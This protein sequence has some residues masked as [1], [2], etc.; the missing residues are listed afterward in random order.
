PEEI[1]R[2][3]RELRRIVRD[4]MRT[5]ILCDNA[6]QCERLDEL[7]ADGG[8]PSPAALTVG[9]L[10]GGFV[11][12]SPDGAGLR[13]LTDHEIFRRERRIRRARTYTS[14]ITGDTLS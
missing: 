8:V 7:L 12:P 6:G 1:G 14:G 11:V 2:D 9:V 13:V 10:Q 5:M 3:I 4:P